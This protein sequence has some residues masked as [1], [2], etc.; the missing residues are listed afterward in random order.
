[1]RVLGFSAV[2]LS[3]TGCLTY[4]GFLAKE[5]DKRCEELARC[6][7]DIPCDIPSGADTGYGNEVC[8]FDAGLARDCLRGAWQ[9]A[10]VPPEFMYVIPPQACDAVCGQST[11][12]P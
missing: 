11:T 2:F 8:V 4:E 12:T 7:P 10:D 5:S 1:M 6:N 3:T 9:C